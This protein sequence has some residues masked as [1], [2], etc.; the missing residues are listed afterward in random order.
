M[1]AAGFPVTSGIKQG[2]PASGSFFAIALDPF[3]RMLCLR[4][5]V[6][7][8]IASAFA[9]DMGLVTRQLLVCLGIISELAGILFQATAMRLN[10][11]KS[12]I[13]PLGRQTAFSILRHINESLPSLGGVLVK[14]HGRY[15][16]FMVGPTA[17]AVRWEGA[18]AK[19]WQRGMAARDAGGGFFHYVLHYSIYATSVLGY[20]M[21][22][23]ALPKVI[24]R[25][26]ARILQYLTR[27]PW[28]AIPSGCLLA[29]SDFG[30]PRE[31]ASLDESNRAAM[32]RAAVSSEAFA[33]AAA[34]IDYTP[35]DPDA[36]L[37]PR[38]VPWIAS[39]A[40]VQLKA[41]VVD[42]LSKFPGFVLCPHS[43][44][45]HRTRLMLRAA[46]PSPW[47]VLLLKRARRWVDDEA[48]AAIEHIRCNLIAACRVLPPRVVFSTLRLICNG[49][50]TSRRFQDATLNC[51]LC[52]WDEGD[53]IEHYLHCEVML[54]F[55]IKYLPSIGWRFGP[56]H[57]TRRSMLCIELSLSELIATLVANDLLVTTISV[58]TQNNRET[59][60]V[61]ALSARLRALARSSATI[62][63]ALGGS[64]VTNDLLYNSAS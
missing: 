34:L 14:T 3:L 54:A 15:L 51:H 17:E 13:I 22:F 53:C 35:T 26:E 55:T 32:L 44:V 37:V 7:H 60:P 50:P 18:A 49:L 62:R 30:F 38:I 8:N 2:C 28:N 10:P 45:Q 41:N 56:V 27:G 12:V 48:P 31:P 11:K 25:M 46:R 29:L 24:L 52:G 20:L 63:N 64:D 36:L 5:P 1:V 47:D 42:Q 40:I 21:Q 16:G 19:Y 58:I 57:G 59:T 23:A 39:T 6:T 9:D 33:A 4:L 61:Q 43:T